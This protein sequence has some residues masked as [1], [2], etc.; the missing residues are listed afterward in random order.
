MSYHMRWCCECSQNDQALPTGC[1][2]S[3]HEPVR[4]VEAKRV[5]REGG[6]RFVF[7]EERSEN[8]EEES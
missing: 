1:F 3:C 7:R 5:P 6:H 2:C 8:R 4:E